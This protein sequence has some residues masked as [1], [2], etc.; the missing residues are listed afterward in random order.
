M[1]KN[2]Q[3]NHHELYDKIKYLINEFNSCKNEKVNRTSTTLEE[4][5]LSKKIIIIG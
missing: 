3:S 4:A 2:I 1:Y 5:L